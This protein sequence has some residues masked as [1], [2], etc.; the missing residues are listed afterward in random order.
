[1]IRNWEFHD[2][3]MDFSKHY[4]DNDHPSDIDLFYLCRDGC[5]V[6]GE[7]K[8]IRDRLK[9]G[10]RKILELLAEGW[11]KDA[12]VLFI[13]H[14]KF[15]QYGDREVDVDCCPVKEIYYKSIHGWR[16]PREPTTVRQ[17]IDYYKERG[18]TDAT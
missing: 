13:Q 4:E 15:Y 5:L 8:N 11:E 12:V 6:L 2:L 9:H 10:Q 1:M 7:I 18:R 17:V 14:D 16:T 3:H